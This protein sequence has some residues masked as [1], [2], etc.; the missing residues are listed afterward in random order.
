MKSHDLAK[1]ML[2]LPNQFVYMRPTAQDKISP[3]H[4]VVQQLN[5]II[6]SSTENTDSDSNSNS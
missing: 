1:M 3:C 5:G 4:H 2:A 6:L